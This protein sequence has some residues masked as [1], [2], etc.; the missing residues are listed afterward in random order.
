M[1]KKI[2][3]IDDELFIRELVQDFLEIEGLFCKIAA[4]LDEALALFKEEC[5]DLV[6]L[7]RNLGDMQA[8]EVLGELRAVQTKIPIIM[9]TGDLDIPEKLIT[10]F[11][12]STVINKP[13]Q[14]DEFIDIINKNL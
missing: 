12:I 11:N 6:L 2:L 9:M 4:N 7:D 10:D 8:E 1:G 14:Y 5:F 3:V 13:F